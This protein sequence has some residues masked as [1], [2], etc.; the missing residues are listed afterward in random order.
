M[1]SGIASRFARLSLH[2]DRGAR[3]EQTPHVCDEALRQAL[4]LA[5]LID[6]VNLR[7]RRERGL[8]CAIDRCD[9]DAVFAH[10]LGLR[11]VDMRDHRF[12][13]IERDQPEAAPLAARAHLRGVEAG[14][15]FSR[16]AL[17]DAPQRGA[18]ARAGRARQQ[19]M[20]FQRAL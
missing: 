7:L 12:G 19:Q 16:K 10:A 11:E 18:L 6:E 13:A 8:D 15:L 4:H 14:Q 1:S 17:R 20:A 5:D 9:I 2:D 3:G